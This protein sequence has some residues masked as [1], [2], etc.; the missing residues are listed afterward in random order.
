MSGEKWTLNKL[1]YPINWIDEK[2]DVPRPSEWSS[3]LQGMLIY[4]SKKYIVKDIAKK[5]I[6]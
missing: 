4:E 2:Y 1:G 6:K 3:T 5:I